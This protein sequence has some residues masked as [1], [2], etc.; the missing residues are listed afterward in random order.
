M[1]L[2]Y[3]VTT[4]QGGIVQELTVK[5]RQ[6]EFFM[7]SR[8]KNRALEGT[9]SLLDRDAATLTRLSVGLKDYECQPSNAA[10]NQ[11]IEIS[12]EGVQILCS[13]ARMDE[14]EA[15]DH[16]IQAIRG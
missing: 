5:G 1:N 12:V 16:L 3:V 2:H 7:F 10:D 4:L 13:E 8:A 14:N 9:F 11:T 15:V 6:A